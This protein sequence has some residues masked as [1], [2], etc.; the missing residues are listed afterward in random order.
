MA[1]NR[2]T[3]FI[4]KLDINPLYTSNFMTTSL[5]TFVHKLVTPSTHEQ[6]HTRFS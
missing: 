2:G 1:L 5:P 3:N 6:F 4:E